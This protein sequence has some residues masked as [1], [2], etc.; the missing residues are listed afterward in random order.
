M[1]QFSLII[2]GNKVD[3]QESFPVLNPATEEVVAQCPR[4]TE[5]QL[6]LAWHMKPF[7]FGLVL[8]GTWIVPVTIVILMSIPFYFTHVTRTLGYS[9]TGGVFSA[10]IFGFLLTVAA[11]IV[12]AQGAAREHEM[13]Q[14]A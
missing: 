8:F 11:A 5:E 4:A 12:F 9:V 1:N 6:D 13:A 10:A 14:A 2:D 3:T 7:L